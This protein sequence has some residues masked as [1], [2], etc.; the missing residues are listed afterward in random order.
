MYNPKKPSL[1]GLVLF[2]ALL[3]SIGFIVHQGNRMRLLEM[4]MDKIESEE[5]DVN[6]IIENTQEFQEDIDDIIESFD[7]V[8]NQLVESQGITREEIDEL[9]DDSKTLKEENE[10]LE[11]EL[12]I[13]RSILIDYMTTGEASFPPPSIESRKEYY[14]VQ[15]AVSFTMISSYPFKNSSM[16]IWYPNETLA[17]E[18]QP[19][20]WVYEVD[21]WIVYP[22]VQLV[23]SKPM[24]IGDEFPLGAYTFSFIN[25]NET[26]VTGSFMIEATPENMLGTGI[27]DLSTD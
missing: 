22:N 20:E 10:E 23:D 6:Q 8:F 1:T 4:R 24:I 7:H 15:D 21:M 9:L 27:T 13:M 2:I 18:T 26:Q 14:H 12:N 3:V 5:K 19:L 17:W 16:K 25:G 11:Y